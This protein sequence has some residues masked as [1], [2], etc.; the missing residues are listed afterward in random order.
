MPMTRKISDLCDDCPQNGLVP[1][2]TESCVESFDTC[3]SNFL[4]IP[5]GLEAVHNGGSG[6]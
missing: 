2:G 5:S 1:V 3:M 4:R 6:V